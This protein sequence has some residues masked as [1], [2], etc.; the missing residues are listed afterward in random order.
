MDDYTYQSNLIDELFNNYILDLLDDNTLEQFSESTRIKLSKHCYKQQL[1]GFEHSINAISRL[2]RLSAT[3][4][5]DINSFLQ[6][7]T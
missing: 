7:K 5:I 2:K 3:Q 1:E 4:E 6:I